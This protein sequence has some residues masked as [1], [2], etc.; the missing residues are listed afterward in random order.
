MRL[1]F[2]GVI[3]YPRLR[4]RLATN[5]VPFA[6]FEQDAAAGT[7]PEFSLIEP[8]FKA[9]TAAAISVRDHRHTEAVPVGAWSSS[10]SAS[11]RRRYR[12]VV[13]PFTPR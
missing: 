7:L 2:H 3:H 4:D 13:S 8:N 9:L 10:L 5:V 11:S 1:S 12:S 6:E